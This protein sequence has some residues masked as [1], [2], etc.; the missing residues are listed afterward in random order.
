LRRALCLHPPP[1][2]AIKIP[3]SERAVPTSDSFRLEFGNFRAL[4]P[5]SQPSLK[6]N[7]S[8]SALFFFICGGRPLLHLNNRGLYRIGISPELSQIRYQPRPHILLRNPKDA[9]GQKQWKP[10][11]SQI[12]V[13]APAGEDTDEYHRSTSYLNRQPMD[14]SCYQDQ[15]KSY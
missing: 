3:A 1:K 15:G 11:K 14:C 5:L 12:T 6:K 4:K 2:S 7:L 8:R 9:L 13:S 10:T